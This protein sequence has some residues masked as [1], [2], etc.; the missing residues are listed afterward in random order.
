[1]LFIFFLPASRLRVLYHTEPHR[2]SQLPS[3]ATLSR[4]LRDSSSLTYFKCIRIWTGRHHTELNMCSHLILIAM[5]LVAL[6]SAFTPSIRPTITITRTVYVSRCENTTS[7]TPA[8]FPTETGT[9]NLEYFSFLP[10]LHYPVVLIHVLTPIQTAR[11]RR[12]PSRQ[13]YSCDA[14]PNRHNSMVSNENW[15][16]D[17]M[18]SG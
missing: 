18:D 1:M 8:Q 5:S 17:N 4:S 14:I 13:F 3:L 7:T 15:R 11:N 6:A 16:S 2:A 12:R 9:P 10:L